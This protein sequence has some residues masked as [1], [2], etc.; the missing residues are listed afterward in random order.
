MVLDAVNGQAPPPLPLAF[1][2]A[3][4]TEA[5]SLALPGYL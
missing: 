2:R 5:R 1:R 3:H 4:A